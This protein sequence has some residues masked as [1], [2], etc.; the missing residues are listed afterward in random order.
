MTFFFVV[1][2]GV[3]VVLCRSDAPIF[4]PII[5]GAFDLLFALLLVGAWFGQSRVA[6]DGAALTVTR[7]WLFVKRER[8]FRQDEVREI[9]TKSGMTSGNKV[10]LDLKARTDTHNE[11]PLASSIASRAEAEWLARKI[12][13]ALGLGKQP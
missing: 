5:F 6:A 4:F 12:S 11:V 10:W 1:W 7:R 13:E 9:F 2:T 3:V 8:R